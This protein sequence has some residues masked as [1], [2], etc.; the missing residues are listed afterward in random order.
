MYDDH[1]EASASASSVQNAGPRMSSGAT[2]LA[3]M[4]GRQVGSTRRPSDAPF[5]TISELLKYHDRNPQGREATTASSLL[6]IGRNRIKSA[7]ESATYGTTVDR[8]GPAE[9]LV[10]EEL[11]IFVVADG[12]V[13]VHG[14]RIGE[15]PDRVA[16]FEHDKYV[17]TR[18]WVELVIEATSIYLGFVGRVVPLFELLGHLEQ[19]R[20]RMVGHDA[21]LV[22]LVEHVVVQ[23][24]ESRLC[25]ARVLVLDNGKSNIASST[26]TRYK[27][28]HKHRERER[29]RERERSR[30]RSIGIGSRSDTYIDR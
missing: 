16:L 24:V 5:E 11:S 18:S 21:E 10:P 15:P 28:N 9:R 4:V 12:E 6:V 1:T 13:L 30:E 27:H 26:T 25:V 2:Y 29:E 23:L 19:M 3:L 8:I 20:K 17:R 7:T 14:S 22:L